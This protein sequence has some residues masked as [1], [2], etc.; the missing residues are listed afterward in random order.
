MEHFNSKWT[1]ATLKAEALKYNT[2]KD[3]REKSK[4]AYLAA[5]RRGIL[6][7]ITSHMDSLRSPRFTI[8]SALLEADNYTS[9]TEFH[10]NSSG[11]YNY[12]KRQGIDV[13]EIIAPVDKTIWTKSKIEQAALNFYTRN[14]FKKRCI[15]GYNAARKHNILDEVCKH[16]D[17]PQRE[18]TYEELKTAALIYK[19]KTEFK[20]GDYGKYQAACRKGIIDEIGSHMQLD[21]H[22]FNPMKPA[23]LYYFKID[24]IWKIGVTNYTIEDRYY[25]RDRDRM[26]NILIWKFDLG[27][28]AY[29]CEQTILKLNKE[30]K[31][32]GET[33]FTDGTKATECFTIDILEKEVDA[34]GEAIE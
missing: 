26:S 17:T 34:S 11:A 28:E 12:L 33:P 27:A 31:Y 8:D 4:G 19:T 18:Y 5:Y 29:Q 16:M 1:E 7:D 21:Q 30:Y 23:I 10:K 9:L 6:K 14:D 15:G 20:R 2:N 32:I 25:K 13:R 24:S 22:S 3:F